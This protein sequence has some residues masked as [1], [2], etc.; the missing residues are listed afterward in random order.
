MGC[1][2]AE[3]PGMCVISCSTSAVGAWWDRQHLSI[4]TVSLEVVLLCPLIVSVFLSL[5]LITSCPPYRLR[6]HRKLVEMQD[7]TVL[8]FKVSFS[9]KHRAPLPVRTEDKK[10]PRTKDSFISQIC[11]LGAHKVAYVQV[12]YAA[13]IFYTY[14]KDHKR[15]CFYSTTSL[16]APGI[17]R[18]FIKLLCYSVITAVLMFHVW[19]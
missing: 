17:L 12:S 11:F 8:S 15:L 4:C 6:R 14:T 2:C 3:L 5:F 1:H 19:L 18:G 7:V 16:T 13:F 10:T 9:M